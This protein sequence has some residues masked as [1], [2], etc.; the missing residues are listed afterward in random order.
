MTVGCDHKSWDNNILSYFQKYFSQ[1]NWLENK[2]HLGFIQ[3]VGQSYWIGFGKQKGN[4][5][6][7]KWC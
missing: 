7:N 4:L 6:G 1:N 5:E 3:V 2:M